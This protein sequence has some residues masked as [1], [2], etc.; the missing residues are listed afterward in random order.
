MRWFVRDL[1]ECRRDSRDERFGNLAGGRFGDLYRGSLV[2]SERC[3][4]H[5]ERHV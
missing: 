5:P 2:H 4:W 3:A 1:N